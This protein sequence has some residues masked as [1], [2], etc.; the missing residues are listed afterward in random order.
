MPVMP[1]F[2]ALAVIMR[3]KPSSDAAKVFG[4]RRGR[5][6][7]RPG[8]QRI[9]DRLDADRAADLD[10]E[11]G[12]RLRG[13]M[14]GER[15]LG[16]LLDLARGKLLE[17]QIERHHLG[18]RG[19]IARLAGFGRKQRLAGVGIDDDRRIFRPRGRCLG[20]R[21]KA[22]GQR[23]RAMQASVGWKRLHGY[24]TMPTPD[25]L[26]HPLTLVAPRGGKG[27]CLT[28]ESN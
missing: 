11:L 28:F 27:S 15:H 4:D 7:G 25:A 16:R 3:A 21:R 8:D 19:R 9:D 2:F 26:L 24:E 6:V 5:V 10:A 13:G 17:H 1:S 14:R 12:R 23:G 18:E 20:D 22:D